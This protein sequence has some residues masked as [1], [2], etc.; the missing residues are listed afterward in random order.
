[1]K[2]TFTPAILL[3]AMGGCGRLPRPILLEQERP[4]LDRCI[5]LTHGFERAGE[6]Y[7]SPDM[8]WIIFQAVPSG[9]QDYQMYVAP[10]VQRGGWIVDVGQPVQISPPG[11]RN[12]CGYFSPDGQSLI[13][14][15]TREKALATRPSRPATRGRYAW[16]FTPEMEIWAL[17]GW[18]AFVRQQ[19]RD[20][21]RGGFRWQR[22]TN[23][24]AYDAECAYSPDGKWI[25]Y[26]STE[27]GD[28]DIYVMRADGT[29]KVRI[30]NAR[31]YDGG[32]F[33]SP[34]G[35]RLVYRSDR[36][37]DDKLQIFV[38]DLAFDAAGNI[39]GAARERQ[40]T[41]DGFNNW[42]PYWHPDGRH[43][44]YATNCHG[45]ANYELYMIRDDGTDLRRITYAD[46]ADVLPVFSADGKYLMW[47]S[48]RTRNQ[49]VQVL[50]AR[51]QMGEP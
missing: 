15:S 20:A 40:I 34:D 41:S 30:T 49:T 11:S 25:V 17:H 22:L 14:A 8:R 51:F 3:L 5:Q 12:T 16:E 33:F 24:Q 39:T 21:S 2:W 13:F 4:A 19:G 47:T 23:N 46:G 10:L 7:F 27:S 26:C 31:G 38:A 29:G 35:K 28:A 42:A 45:H 50:L 44:I 18:Q 43:I 37:G 48:K 9:Q 6:A 36:K 1:V 32:P